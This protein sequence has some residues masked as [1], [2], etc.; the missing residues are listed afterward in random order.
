M[1]MATPAFPQKA[2]SAGGSETG[3]KCEQPFVTSVGSGDT[4]M[5]SQEDSVVVLGAGST[6]NLVCFSWLAPR[7]RI[8]ERR[9]IP[10]V[11]AYPPQA[12]FRFGDGR[13]GEVRRAVDILAG[14]AGNK[15][16]PAAFAPEGGIPALL[17]QGAIEAFVGLLDFLR[18]P[19]NL[20]R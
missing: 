20:H 1:S 4:F 18:G 8:L 14:I 15:G 5:V 10:R 13:F 19:L 17:R 6:A 12:R 7:N 9:G 3:S 16:A 11:A 2:E